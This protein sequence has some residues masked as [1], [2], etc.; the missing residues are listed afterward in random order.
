MRL[1]PFLLALALFPQPGTAQR[2]LANGSPT[3]R[4]ATVAAA[5]AVRVARPPAIDGKDSDDAWRDAPHIDGFR[6][7]DPVEDGDPSMRTDATSY[8]VP[9]SSARPTPLFV[10]NVRRS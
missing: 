1:A 5:N 3:R 4:A 8:A 2:L 6:V 7:F 9:S 10:P